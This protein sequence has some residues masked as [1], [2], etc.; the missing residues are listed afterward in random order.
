MTATSRKF[1]TPLLILGF[2][3]CN[4]IGK[5]HAA[6]TSSNDS[7]LP[8]VSMNT[9]RSGHTATLLP[10]G[11]VLFAGGMERNGTYFNSVELYSPMTGKFH[12]AGS[13][14]AARVGHT[15]TL[16]PNG[17]VLI[18]GGFD[19]NGSLATAE[20]YDPATDTFAAT[21]S[22][23]SRRGDFTATLLQSGKVLVAGGE[24]NTALSSAELYDPAIRKFVPTNSMTSGR[25]MQTA[26]LLPDGQVLIAGGGPYQKPLATAE[27]YNPASGIFSS[28]GKMNIARY[29][30]AAQLLPDGNVLIMGGSDGRDRR[31]QYSSAEVYDTSRNTFTSVGSMTTARY[32]FPEAVVRLKTGEIF[33]AGGSERSEVYDVK[34]G[35][36]S[37][38]DGQ[39]D[40][41]RSYS[42]ATLLGD[43][44]VLIA[45]GYDDHGIA[46]AKAWVYKV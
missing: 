24:D 40:G 2:V 10:N 25:T 44:R 6:L 18:V 27:L 31:G 29:K 19:G 13:M 28:T 36:F 22:M 33:I 1:L 14:S 39:M 37:A 45:G 3:A 23:A 17:K 12:P 4:T 32:K 41:A 43:G 30:H 5:N 8:T 34:T 9:P 15:A 20:V 26:T 7:I 35:A 38:V 46:T 11:K 21:G 42:T 16:L